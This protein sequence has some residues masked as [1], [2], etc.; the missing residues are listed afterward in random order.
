ML[1]SS[2]QTEVLVLGI[3]NLLWADE[4]FGVRAIEAFHRQYDDHPAVRLMDGG[5]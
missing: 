1:D 4:G 5:T 2:C 3:G